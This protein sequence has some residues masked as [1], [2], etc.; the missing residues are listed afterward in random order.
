ME[1]NNDKLRGYYEVLVQN[2]QI[3]AAYHLKLKNNPVTFTAI[4]MIE[5]SAHGKEDSMFFFRV[6][7][8]A[9]HKGTYEKPVKDIEDLKRKE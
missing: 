9:E 1:N 3:G 5:A 7:E 2:S 8:P 6:L 4:P